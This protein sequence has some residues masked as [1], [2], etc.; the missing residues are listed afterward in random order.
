LVGL[1]YRFILHTKPPK[2]QE[3]QEKKED[4]QQEMGDIEE[5]GEIGEASS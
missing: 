5:G 1:L 2:K 4:Q 3:E